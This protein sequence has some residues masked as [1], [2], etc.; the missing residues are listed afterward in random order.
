M[1]LQCAFLPPKYRHQ[2]RSRLTVF[3]LVSSLSVA[4]SIALRHGYEA[5]ASIFGADRDSRALALALLYL[6]QLAAAVSA[7]CA[8]AAFPRRPDIYDKAGLVDQQHTLSLLSRFSFSWN[9][10]I[11]D[12]AKVRQMEVQDIPNLDHITRSRY[13]QA[14]FLERGA[15]GPLW[16]QLIVAHAGELALQWFLTLIIALLSL[17]PQVV[18]YNFLSRIERSQN[19]S[20]ADPTVFIWV[21]GLL[22]SQI[23]QVGVNNWLKWITA[24]RLEI[25]VSSLLQSL[26]F[27]K[28]LKQYETAPPGQNLDKG[29]SDSPG[30]AKNDSRGTS[31][32]QQAG[33]TKGKVPET[34]QS[35]INHMKLDRYGPPVTQTR[36]TPR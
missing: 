26:V 16:K 25:P 22:L 9:R 19:H 24:S 1:C 14:K 11:F 20:S 2:A 4:V 5:L 29:S 8:F 10:G 32:E 28:A 6:L 34:R 36:N 7:A 33:K 23:L 15:K 31:T 18:L 27:S 30:G 35:V 21:F 12:V 3:G 13:L 17:F